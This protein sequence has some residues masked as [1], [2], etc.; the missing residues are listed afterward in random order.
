MKAR[1]MLDKM[2]DVP[3][4]ER[5]LEAVPIAVPEVRRAYLE[6]TAHVKNSVLIGGLA[7]GVYDRPRTTMDVDMLFLSEEAVPRDVPGFKRLRAHAFEH[8]ASGVEVEALT[9]AF[10]KMP[11]AL[12]QKIF[13][14]ARGGVVSPEGLVAAKLQRASTQDRT[15]VE[16]IL[17][18]HPEATLEGW[19]L[20]AAQRQLLVQIRAS[21]AP[22]H[23][24]PPDE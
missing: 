21:D 16:N 19:P 23:Q 4:R 6:W 13:D 10:L 3:L 14:T 22:R 9:P 8:R 24:T 12:A 17:R 5:L 1:K 11:D 7:V 2:F 20:T 15:D 18:A